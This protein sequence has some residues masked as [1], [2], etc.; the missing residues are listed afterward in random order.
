[1]MVVCIAAMDVVVDEFA[2]T[3]V[4]EHMNN[5]P[6]HRDRFLLIDARGEIDSRV[7]RLSTIFGVDAHVSRA[8]AS[9]WCSARIP[10]HGKIVDKE[11]GLRVFKAMRNETFGKDARYLAFSF[12]ARPE[13]TVEKQYFH[14]PGSTETMIPER[15]LRLFISGLLICC[16]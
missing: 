14:G 12:G 4:I 11:T 5:H 1:M 8:A 15:Y 9:A 13:K 10:V 3:N 6:E 7:R 16:C 2:D